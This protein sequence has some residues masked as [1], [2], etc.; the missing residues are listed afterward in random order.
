MRILMR[1]PDNIY[2]TSGEWQDY[3]TPSRDARTKTSFVE[4]RNRVR[5]LLK[6]HANNPAS[7]DYNGNDL[8][9]DMKNAYNQATVACRIQYRNST[10]NTI[11]LEYAELHKRLF[12]LSFDPYTVP[13][14]DG[15]PPAMS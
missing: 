2:D 15:A 5:E 7:L 12:K 13:N 11:Q 14:S 3:S 10:G 4:L 1:L 8:A 6:Q 9:A